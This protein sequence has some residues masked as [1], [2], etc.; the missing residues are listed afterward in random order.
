[1]ENQKQKQKEIDLKP[2]KQ[3]NIFLIDFSINLK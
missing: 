1:M 3:S 2:C